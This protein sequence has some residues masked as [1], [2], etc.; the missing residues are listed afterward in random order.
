MSSFGVTSIPLF[1]SCP[2]KPPFICGLAIASSQLHFLYL[3]LLLRRG[4]SFSCPAFSYLEEQNNSTMQESYGQSCS[5][6]QERDYIGLSEA[7]SAIEM[8]SMKG[9]DSLLED[10][11]LRLGLGLGLA[12]G[13]SCIEGAGKQ[14]GKEGLSEM[15]ERPASN[16][17]SGLKRGI[18][19]VVVSSS[20]QL[21]SQPV[22]DI[23]TEDSATDDSPPSKDQIVGW[24]PVRLYRK[25]TLAKPVEM[26]VKVNMDGM[27]VGRKVDL[28][29]CKSY[30]GLLLALEEMFRPSQGGRESDI[31]HF[32]LSSEPDYVLTYEDKEGD[33][34]LV[35]DVPWS[36]FTSTVRRLRITRGSE[37]NG[38]VSSR[39]HTNFR[40]RG[41]N[42]QASR[43]N[44]FWVFM[45]T[46]ACWATPLSGAV[47]GGPNHGLL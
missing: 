9:T 44:L 43:Q 7:A 20:L 4:I 3:L 12:L 41:L 1:H 23:S 32:L 17:R 11:D 46:S 37:A 21:G 16:Q 34:M 47:S 2:E 25:Q 19:E 31:K 13:S 39:S 27:T 26:F 38:T 15:S 42:K 18:S 10:A 5:S 36:M 14:L 33:W 35:G 45:I 30:K 8:R 29:A 28:S 24:P 40:S 22:S 6:L